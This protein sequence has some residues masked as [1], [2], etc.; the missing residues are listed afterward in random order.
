MLDH[1]KYANI[2]Y[3][4]EGTTIFINISV[5]STLSAYQNLI[6][7]ITASFIYASYIDT[8]YSTATLIIKTDLKFPKQ[9]QLPFDCRSI[10]RNHSLFS[11]LRG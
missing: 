6:I 1:N 3:K 2:T 7:R 11:V 8:H 4:Y 10:T 5:I 9:M